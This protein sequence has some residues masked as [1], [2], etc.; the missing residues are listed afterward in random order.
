MKGI[1]F[2]NDAWNDYLYW[3]TQ[4]KKTLRRINAL[5]KD[6]QRDYYDGIG[7]PEALKH[8]FQ[9]KWS[10]RIDSTNRLVYEILNNS[11]IRIIQCRGH[12]DD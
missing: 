6:I 9:G 1:N 5:L 10:R 12:Y 3:Q 7:E 4:D 8:E 2:T 11:D